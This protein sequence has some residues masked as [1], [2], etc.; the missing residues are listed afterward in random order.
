M[1]SL[2]SK[3]IKLEFMVGGNLYFIYINKQNKVSEGAMYSLSIDEYDQLSKVGKDETIEKRG[4]FISKGTI[5]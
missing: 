3:E 4:N 5:P 2:G 1:L